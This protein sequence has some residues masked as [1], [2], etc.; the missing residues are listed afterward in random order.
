MYGDSAARDEA[1]SIGFPV[2][3]GRPSPLLN[4]FDTSVRSKHSVLLVILIRAHE[5]HLAVCAN[6]IRSSPCAKPLD[7]SMNTD[8]SSAQMTLRRLRYSTLSHPPHY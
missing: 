4:R 8:T 1:G 2:T 6:A 7:N 3:E 5:L